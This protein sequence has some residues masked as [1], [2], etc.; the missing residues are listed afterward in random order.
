MTRQQRYFILALDHVSAMQGQDAEIKDD[1]A[2]LCHMMPPLVRNDGLCQAV[3]WIEAKAQAHPPTSLS[4]AY[5][6]LRTH[7]ASLLADGAN[8]HA[9]QLLTKVR[10]ASVTDYMRYTTVL[11]A[12]SIYYKR[13]VQSVLGLTPTDADRVRDGGPR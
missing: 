2:A 13:F 8:D 3:A 7:I 5:G 9:D 10:E 4:M 11:L 1:Y 6:L 12:A